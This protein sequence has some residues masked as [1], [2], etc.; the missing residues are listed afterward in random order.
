[1]VILARVIDLKQNQVSVFTAFDS[2]VMLA[3][4]SISRDL[5]ILCRQRQ[6][7]KPIT[8]P[9]AHARGVITTRDAFHY[10]RTLIFYIV[11]NKG[12]KIPHLLPHTQ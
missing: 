1:M 7:D 4:M 3:Q 2:L 9:L 11:C 8:L 12:R 5:A 6:T 10:H